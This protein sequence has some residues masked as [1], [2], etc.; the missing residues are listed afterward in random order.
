MKH[1]F[2][3]ATA[4]LSVTLLLL[5]AA[6]PLQKLA[7]E[8]RQIRPVCNLNGGG[9]VALP[10]PASTL[11]DG[12]QPASHPLRTQIDNTNNPQRTAE[13]AMTEPTIG[14][15]PSEDVFGAQTP[16]LQG[17][18]EAPK[19]FKAAAPQMGDTRIVDGQKKQVY[20][21]GFGW[22]ADNSDDTTSGGILVDGDGDI[23][24]MV[25]IMG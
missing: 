12:H 8:S 19:P 18:N 22:I 3:I 21:L 23:N 16:R 15:V 25:G 7:T 11:V 4:G 2:A 13:Y 9:G 20:F 1:K 17:G 6:P 24:K 10:P 5:S 14:V